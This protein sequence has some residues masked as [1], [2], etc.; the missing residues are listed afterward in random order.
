MRAAAAAV[1]HKRDDAGLSAAA[2]VSENLM[3][4]S[5]PQKIRLDKLGGLVCT[6]WMT[7]LQ[8]Q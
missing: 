8:S 6:R 4:A 7:L 1:G 3:V 2:V 5:Q